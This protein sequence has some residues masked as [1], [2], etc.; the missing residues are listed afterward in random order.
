MYGD[1][2]PSFLPWLTGSLEANFK[3]NYSKYLETNGQFNCD[4]FLQDISLAWKE[5]NL[6]KSQLGMQQQHSRCETYRRQS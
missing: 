6:E 3:F 2:F 4:L 5:A 1:Y